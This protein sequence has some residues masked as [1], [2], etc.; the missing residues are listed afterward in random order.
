LA[1]VGLCLAVRSAG[2]SEKDQQQA[3]RKIVSD[4]ACDFVRVF[5]DSKALGKQQSYGLFVPK[6]Y[7]P[8]KR[9]PV[10]VFLHS[11]YTDFDDK[12]WLRV[13]EIPGTIQHQCNERGWIAIG[14]EAGGNSWYYGKAEEQVLE[15]V[16][17]V[18]KYLSID[19]QRLV[20]I[21]RSMGGGGALTIAMHHPD[22]VIGTVALAPITDYLE[23][24][25]GNKE[26]LLAANPGSVR[27]AFGG[28]PEEVPKAYKAMNAL[29]GVDALAK[30]PVYLIH[31]ADDPIVNVTHS[32]KLVP[33]LEKAGGKVK[34]VEVPKEQHNMEMIEWYA[35]DYF[36]FLEANAKKPAARESRRAQKNVR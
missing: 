25:L 24:S 5:Y 18:A 26:L 28:L 19:K 30:M 29:E 35:P 7:D 15:T 3:I 33:L 32:R 1:I 31:G 34:Y 36:T 14:P 23:F 27:T 9:N 21:G 4:H 13:T 8:S 12:Q 11:W 10:V 16:D 22:R 20:L 2:A 17:E 6:S